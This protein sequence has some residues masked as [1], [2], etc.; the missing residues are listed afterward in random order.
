MNDSDHVKSP[1]PDYV[2]SLTPKECYYLEACADLA[3]ERGLV[4]LLKNA[5]RYNGARGIFRGRG[6]VRVFM[7]LVSLRFNEILWA[8]RKLAERFH[9][10][11]SDYCRLAGELES[12]IRERDEAREQLQKIGRKAFWASK[13]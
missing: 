8:Y 11:G 5:K 6:M 1:A 7:Q 3:S 10:L 9:Q 2:A 12:V 13:T 4:R